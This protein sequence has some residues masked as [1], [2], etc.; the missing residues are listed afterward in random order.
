MHLP[1]VS[2]LK[3]DGWESVLSWLLTLIPF[4]FSLFCFYFA[5]K[6]KNVK[7]KRFDRMLGFGLITTSVVS[8]IFVWITVVVILGAI[9]YWICKKMR[10][11]W[12]PN[13]WKGIK[14]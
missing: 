10:S 9:L 14:G 7:E 5:G 8:A 1:I 2:I 3:L 4:V 6:D 12:I 13:I 11:D